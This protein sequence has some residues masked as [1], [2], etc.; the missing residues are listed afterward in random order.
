M[1]NDAAAP[2]QPPARWRH[3]SARGKARKRA[4]DVLY[5]SDI[6]GVDPRDVVAFRRQRAEPPIADYT[7]VLVE[8][9]CDHRARIDELLSTYA[10]GWQLSRMPAVDRNIM[11]LGVYELMW[12]EDVPDPVVIDEAVSL[13][14][15]LSTEDSPG[16]INGV[17]GRLQLV[18]DL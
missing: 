9:V 17:L 16:F 10:E 7:V 15:E 12:R 8:G 13:A 5:E 2:Q 14:K 6:R 4:L 18:K 11:R 3:S 1:S